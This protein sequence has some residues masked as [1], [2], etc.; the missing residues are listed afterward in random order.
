MAVVGNGKNAVTHYAVIS[1][2]DRADH[3]MLRLETGRTHQIR[4]HMASLGHPH[5]R[6]TPI[7]GG[8]KSGL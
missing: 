1:R 6:E 2:L 4:V 5:S 8:G 3:V 7:Y